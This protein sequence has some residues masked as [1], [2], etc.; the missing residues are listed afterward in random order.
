MITSQN[1]A[2]EASKITDLIR[3]KQLHKFSQDPAF[4]VL[5]QNLGAAAEGE[6]PSDRAHAAAL[7]CKVGT[8]LKRARPQIAVYLTRVVTKPFPPLRMLDDADNR[9]Y[10]ATFWKFVSPEWSADFLA[11][12]AVHEEAAE[13]VRRECIAGL[14]TTVPTI[15][16]ALRRVTA[17]V[18]EL[19]FQ[20][21]NPLKSK[22]R[23]L[24]RFFSA[25]RLESISIGKEPGKSIGEAL[26]ILVRQAFAADDLRTSKVRDELAQEVL[27]FLHEIL[28]S[29]SDL[30]DSAEAYKVIDT[31][32]DWFSLGDWNDFTE[33][34]AAA[35][36]LAQD[37]EQT[38]ERLI[39]SGIP[40]NSLL[41]LLTVI[42]GG[43]RVAREKLSGILS[44]NP[45][46]T[47]DLVAWLQGREPRLKSLFAQE[48]Q[49]VQTEDDLATLLLEALSGSSLVD[50]F[51]NDILPEM[52]VLG[53]KH[54]G[55]VEKLVNR[56]TALIKEIEASCASR[57][58]LIQGVIGTVVKFS[59]LQHELVDSA[60]F[61]DRNVRIVRPAVVVQLQ[62][63]SYR[64]VRKALVERA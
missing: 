29:R 53:A 59:P 39:K 43:E 40:D 7:L 50:E 14:L 34:S 28:K 45:L 52:R 61:G 18:R 22:A 57:S 9:Y 10:L 54:T 30:A 8:L 36:L 51:Q 4:S 12:A 32:R 44:R 1:L 25:L 24:R 26:T 64:V 33:D 62:D 56:M 6:T 49:A 63:G 21:E 11:E 38:I 48:S 41:R 35:A 37:L 13:Q 16:S 15:E 19:K 60:H 17:F 23:R 5:L 58:F 20:T 27:A 55:N 31:V 47:E 2:D 46:L 3:K 42:S